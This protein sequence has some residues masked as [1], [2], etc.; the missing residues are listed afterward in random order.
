MSI[1]LK[2]SLKDL[3]QRYGRQ[4]LVICVLLLLVHDIFGTHGFLAMRRKQE[5]IQKVKAELD[6]LNKENAALDEDRQNLKS[7]PQTINK[8]SHEELGLALPGEIIIKI[9][10]PA[11]DNNHQA[12]K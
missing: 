9:A 10:A 4:V 12:K 11:A 1:E 7:D 2:Q 6:R 3:A 8:I 5:E